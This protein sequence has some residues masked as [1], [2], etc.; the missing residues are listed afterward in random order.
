MRKPNLLQKLAIVGVAGAISAISLEIT[1][2]SVQAAVVNFNISQSGWD[3]GGEVMGMFSGEDINEDGFINIVDNEVFSYMIEFKGNAIIPDFTHNLNDLLFFRYTLGSGGFRP[4]FPLF[5]D[6]GSFFY[7]ADDGAI[8]D[9]PPITGR[10]VS[11]ALAAA[12][13]VKIVPEPSTV[14]GLLAFGCLGLGLKRKK[15]V[16]QK[17]GILGNKSGS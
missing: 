16:V 9:S 14:L 10:F 5:S 11:T 6:S 4:S 7:D 2:S 12:V 1:N 3:G 15:G 13:N 17:R 8:G